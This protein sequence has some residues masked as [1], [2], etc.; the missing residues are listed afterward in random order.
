VVDRVIGLYMLFVVA[1]A[2]ILLTGFRR[3]PVEMI[4]VICDVTYWVTVI[5]AIG[6]A[7]L[8]IPAMTEGKLARS[9]GRIPRVGKAL[10]SL[11]EAMRMYRRKPMVL[12]V[13][14]VLSIGVHGLFAMGV[15]CI[16][17]GLP[18]NF[19]SLGAHFVIM[20]LSSATGVLPWAIGP[21]EIVLDSLYAN[22]PL[23]GPPIA[24][25][26]GFVVALGYR[27]IT[28]LIAMVGAVY[29][30]ISRKEVAEAMHEVEETSTIGRG[31]TVTMSKRC[32]ATMAASKDGGARIG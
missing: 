25:H 26:Q 10:D 30:F 2:A 11:I 13:A 22:V 6:I 19:H 32:P 24:P 29:C 17:R 3:Q 21:F 14:A 27:V 16:A 18:G 9:L 8:M 20:P 1:S 23:A 12:F 7:V 15:Y 5:G 31:P 28:V 4:R